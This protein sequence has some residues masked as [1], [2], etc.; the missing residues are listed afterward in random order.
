MK[1]RRKILPLLLQILNL[2]SST[3][4]G[5]KTKRKEKGETGV[6]LHGTF[7]QGGKGRKGNDVSA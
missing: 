5:K 3:S 2:P 7:P 1:K 6:L 4:S